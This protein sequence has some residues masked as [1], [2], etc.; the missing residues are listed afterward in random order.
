MTANHFPL[1]HLPPGGRN[2][3]FTG[4]EPMLA[5]LGAQLG[6]AQG[7]VVVSQAITGLGGVGKTQLAVEYIYRQMAD[8]Q[9]A[10]AQTAYDLVWWL[11]ADTVVNLAADMAALAVAVGAISPENPDQQAALNAAAAGWRRRTNGGCCWW[12]MPMTCRRAR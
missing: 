11:R 1:I 8:R 2:P 4:R 3:N 12:T 6:Q 5:R 7:T 9:Q 10:D